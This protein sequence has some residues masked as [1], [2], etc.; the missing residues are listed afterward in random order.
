MMQRSGSQSTPWVGILLVT[1]LQKA[2]KNLES[3]RC[4]ARLHHMVKYHAKKLSKET[5]A[6]LRKK[7]DDA[8]EQEDQAQAPYPRKRRIYVVWVKQ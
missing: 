3:G 2:K 5:I 4:A 7:D 1:R 6:E 8:N